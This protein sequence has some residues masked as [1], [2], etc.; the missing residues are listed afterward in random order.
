MG[1]QK[2]QL[3]ANTAG[4]TLLGSGTSIV[5]MSPVQPGAPAVSNP[6]IGTTEI[7]GKVHAQAMIAPVL[8][9]ILN[10]GGL[11]NYEVRWMPQAGRDGYILQEAGS[12]SF[13][14][15]REIYKGNLTSLACSNKP[16]GPFFYRVCSYKGTENSPWS[17]AQSTKVLHNP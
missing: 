5:Q 1:G 6:V 7:A 10:M 15:A 4:P 14:D 17:E 3:A 16:V 9:P 8:F 13:R 11:P 2:Q 12:S